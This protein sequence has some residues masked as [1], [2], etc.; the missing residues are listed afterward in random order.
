[1]IKYE[2][3]SANHKQK[4]ACVFHTLLRIIWEKFSYFY[5]LKPNCKFLWTQT[6]K[7]FFSSL[8]INREIEKEYIFDN[9]LNEI[10]KLISNIKRQKVLFS[11]FRCWNWKMKSQTYNN[12]SE[13]VWDLFLCKIWSLVEG[14]RYKFQKWT[15]YSDKIWFNSW[16]MIFS[17]LHS[18]WHFEIWQTSYW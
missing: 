18:D 8:S 10:D 3:F 12:S 15:F 14:H 6:M 4:S 5:V 17:L 13:V 16:S 11:H 9:W 7:N 2:I 1:M